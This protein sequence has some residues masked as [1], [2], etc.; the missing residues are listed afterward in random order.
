MPDTFYSM[1]P[2]PIRSPLRHLDATKVSER[3]RKESRNREIHLPPVSVYR[4]W[5]RRT[6]AVNESILE[7]FERDSS[8]R[9]LV[10][11][12][13][14]G[15]GVI[16]F[17]AVLRGH[18]V[19]A[20]DINP[21]ATL[22]LSTALRFPTSEDLVKPLEA[23]KRAMA[24]VLC[25]AY[26][27]RMADGSPGEVA[28]TFRVRTTMCTNCNETLRLFPHSVVSLLSRKERGRTAC[29]LACRAGH[30]FVA[31]AEAKCECP[32]CAREVAGDTSYT[33][34]R[35]VS[36]WNCSAVMSLDAPA[37]IQTSGWEVALVE[38]IA[39]S[40]RRELAIPSTREKR[41]AQGPWTAKRDLGKIPPGAETD[42]LIRHGFELWS[43]LY[44]DRQRYV[45]EV[46]LENIDRLTDAAVRDALRLAALGTT[47]MAGHASRWDRW[48]LKSYES[49]A[50]HRFNFTTFAV[51]PNVWGTQSAGRG[52]FQRRVMQVKK[53]SDWMHSLAHPMHRVVGPNENS[54]GKF[55]A[56]VVL[57]SSEHLKLKGRSIALC[58]T[59]PPY[60]DDV[61]YSELSLPLRA[62]AGLGTDGLEGEAVVNE[63]AGVNV[64]HG[65]Y[66]DLLTRIFSEVERT[67]RADGH[68][69][70]SYANRRPE[71]WC[72]ILSALRGAGF[73]CAGYSIVHSENETDSAK[74]DVR[75]CN[76]DLIMDLVP[77]S[78]Q[79]VVRWR[80]KLTDPTAEEEFLELVGSYLWRV[81]DLHGDWETR[82]RQILLDSRFL[83]PPRNQGPPSA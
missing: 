62:W 67:L 42:V 69:I 44:P 73:R 3:S 63:K 50:G 56:R 36:C 20:Q 74:R 9:V 81:H 48:Y 45:T 13:F 12:P 49:M 72:D 40:G 23:V 14:A 52:T 19:Y 11:D 8:E 60:H 32:V 43:D 53:A 1:N 54:R 71:A 82:F 59:D 30:V 5:A 68:L 27:T 6:L 39:A 79:R 2:R 70:F 76:L 66:R 10:V 64:A 7:A 15:G 80:P 78:D 37:T 38:R 47:E 34:S 4:W 24:P 33:T 83:R 17:A 35:N 31:D 51:E 77:L 25:A 46:L 75:A 26:S 65:E 18:R 29:Y 41:L 16:P 22:G 21:W 58:L 61:Q 57:G 28:H 55:D